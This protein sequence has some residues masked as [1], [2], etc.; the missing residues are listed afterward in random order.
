MLKPRAGFPPDSG[1]LGQTLAR[2]GLSLSAPF[3][4][5]LI[6][7]TTRMSL[8]V[9]PLTRAACAPKCNGTDTPR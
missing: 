6:S 9:P 7:A 1:H 8:R 3:I 2:K 5:H 4:V